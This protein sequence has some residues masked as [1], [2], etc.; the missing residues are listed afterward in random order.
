MLSGGHAV[1]KSRVFDANLIAVAPP[2]WKAGCGGVDLFA[3]SLSFVNSDQIVQL[4]RSVAANSAGYAFQLTLDNVFPDGAKWIE[5]FQK[6]IQQLNQY[7][8]N[9]CQLAQGVV[10]D[11]AS[12]FDL[13]H[14]TDASLKAT[15]TGLYED[16]FSAR[17]GA[18]AKAAH[19]HR[20]IPSARRTRRVAAKILPPARRS[21][22]RVS[23][24]VPPPP[25][26]ESEIFHRAR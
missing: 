8:G 13:K 25:V 12:G 2:S 3:G 7:L 18:A 4:L 21:R 15:F 14:K 23:F 16:I 22:S 9:S 6:K 1:A 5:N 19:K 17:E 10:N 24:I 26:R 20:P 11:L